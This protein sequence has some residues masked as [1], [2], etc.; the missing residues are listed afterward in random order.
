MCVF[1]FDNYSR[2][3]NDFEMWKEFNLTVETLI[4]K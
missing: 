1:V 2:T 4:K 3:G